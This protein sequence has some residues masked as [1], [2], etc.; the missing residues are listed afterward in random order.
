M[1]QARSF[2]PP[3]WTG[4]VCSVRIPVRMKRVL[5]ICTGNYYRSR[6]AELLFEMLARKR[7]IAWEATSR[8]TSVL[9]LGHHNV[10]PICQFAKR[11]LAACGVRV[12][13][14]PRAPL[15]LVKEDLLRADLI[16]AVCE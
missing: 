6:F 15:Q 10:G 12:D 4:G 2:N 9:S 11:A 3:R 16:V 5:F 13:D 14:T 1:L 7:G 8:G